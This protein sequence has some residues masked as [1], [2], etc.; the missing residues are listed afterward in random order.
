MAAPVKLLFHYD[1]SEI[2]AQIEYDGSQ[3]HTSE[4]S[5]SPTSSPGGA[6]LIHLE[7]QS[8]DSAYD[9]APLLPAK[10]FIDLAAQ[11]ALENY[12]VPTPACAGLPATPARPPSALGPS[13]FGPSTASGDNEELTQ[14]LVPTP[15][16]ESVSAPA[17]FRKTKFRALSA[18]SSVQSSTR[19][20]ATPSRNSSALPSRNGSPAWS[21]PTSRFAGGERFNRAKCYEGKENA[22]VAKG[23]FGPGMYDVRCSKT[24]SPRGEAKHTP[25]F[26]GSERFTR[27]KCYEG[28]E[29]A[30]VAKGAFGPGM[31]DV[32]CSKTG[33]PRGE[34]KHTPRF[35]GSERF[36]RAKCYEGKENAEVAKGIYGPGMY[37]VQCSKTG[38]PLKAKGSPRFAGSER[39]TRAKCYEGRENANALRGQ[40]GASGLDSPRCSNRGSPL[41]NRR[42]EP[43]AAFA[44]PYVPKLRR[45]IMSARE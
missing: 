15:P 18:Q 21:R 33:S 40:A 28:K 42:R 10:V 7:V 12:V 1:G 43:S 38:S 41:W 37:D 45:E 4:T 19:S 8:P 31:Y 16:S 3:N 17:V 36:T 9:D 44:I 13:P 32:R 11:P 34:A 20:S 14:L 29:N 5:E 27:A 25:R 22:E 6:P 35:A 26:A 30:E 23:A 24:G 39:F 2:R